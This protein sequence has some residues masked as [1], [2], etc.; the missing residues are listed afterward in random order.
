M[1]LDICFTTIY[2][3]VKLGPGVGQAQTWGGAIS[4]DRIF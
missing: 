4:F 2:D 3:I 1:S